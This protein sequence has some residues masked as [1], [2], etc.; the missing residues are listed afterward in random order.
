VNWISGIW[1]TDDFKNQIGGTMPELKKEGTKIYCD[2]KNCGRGY[3][4][5]N[6]IKNGMI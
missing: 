4:V 2:F 3:L 5:R 6:A 1:F